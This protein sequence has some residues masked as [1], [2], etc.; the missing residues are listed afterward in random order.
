[1]LGFVLDCHQ[2]RLTDLFQ[3]LNELKLFLNFVTNYRS[4]DDVF[5][6]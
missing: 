6:Y 4:I 2:E 5:V 1:M 3:F